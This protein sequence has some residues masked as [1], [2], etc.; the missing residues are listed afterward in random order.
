MDTEFTEE[1]EYKFQSKLVC[2]YVQDLR[3]DAGLVPA[4]NINIYYKILEESDSS[5]NYDKL[6]I[7]F[8]EKQQLYI[9]PQIRNKLIEVDDSSNNLGDI[10]QKLKEKN[11]NI[12]GFNVKIVLYSII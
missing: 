5:K 1:M 3:K 6:K 9:Q 4:D 11:F 7:L 12:F 2:R 8:N 10:T